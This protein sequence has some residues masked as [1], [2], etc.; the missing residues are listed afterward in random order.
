[1]R[2]TR[3]R[4]SRVYS[5]RGARGDARGREL[6]RPRGTHAGLVSGAARHLGWCRG[7]RHLG[8][9][10]RRYHHPELAGPQLRIAPPSCPRSYRVPSGGAFTGMRAPPHAVAF[11]RHRA[12]ATPGASSCSCAAPL[13][14]SPSWHASLPSPRARWAA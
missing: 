11:A 9:F 12:G 3:A 4:E 14:A 5:R 13:L 1:M 2:W 10:L 7:T 8:H 6:A